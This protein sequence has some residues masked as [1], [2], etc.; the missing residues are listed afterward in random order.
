MKRE[1]KR[2]L[3]AS[4]IAHDRMPGDGSVPKSSACPLRLHEHKLDIELESYL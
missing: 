1:G 4:R 3:A 2:G